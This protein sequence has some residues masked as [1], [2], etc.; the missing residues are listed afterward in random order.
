MRYST[1][2]RLQGTAISWATFFVG[3]WLL[4]LLTAI[5][6]GYWPAVPVIPFWHAAGFILVGLAFIFVVIK[7]FTAAYDTARG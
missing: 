6:H 3:S 4:K 7:G 1:K 5:V 2:R